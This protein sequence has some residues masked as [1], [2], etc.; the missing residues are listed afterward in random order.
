MQFGFST[1]FFVKQPLP[2]VLDAIASSGLT[3]MELSCEIPHGLSM[4]KD[5]RRK[6]ADMSVQGFTFSVHAPFFELNLGSFIE[7][8][9]SIS[10]ER[11][12][13][14]LDLA[15]ELRCDPVVIHPGYTFL[16]NKVKSIEDQTRSQFID[17]L[18]EMAEYGARMGVRIALENVYMP[19][20]FFYDL[21]DFLELKRAVPLIGM[22]LDA[23]HAYVG[24]CMRRHPDPEDAII[25]D[26][27]RIGVENLFHVHL[28]NNTG[29]RD[30]HLFLGGSMDMGRILRALD[31]L[32]Y[33]GKVIIES[34][35]MEEHGIPA[36]LEKL[37]SLRPP[38]VSP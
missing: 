25:R 16:I 37:D 3:T 24:K 1:Y 7:G 4:D 18:A 10:K 32:G 29:V 34:Y 6:V 33:D 8:I 20:F 30:D 31:S 2:G 35:D 15:A 38:P 5:F 9:R 17:D 19:F 26:I 14:A 12:R 27:T 13:E 11:I 22:T 21:P 23:G 28:H 36:V